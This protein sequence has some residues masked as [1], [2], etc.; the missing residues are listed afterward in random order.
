[1][2]KPSHYV[3]KNKFKFHHSHIIAV[4]VLAGYFLISKAHTIQAMRSGNVLT[5]F[6]QLYL[7]GIFFACLFL[8][9]FSHD[10]FF[11]FA[12]DIEKTESKKEKKYLNKYLHHGKILGT[13]I[14]GSIGGPVFS[15]LT[16]RILLNDYWYK[17][18]IVILANIPSTIITVGLGT[19]IINAF[20]IL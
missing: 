4:A 9:V 19:G 14:I 18:L 12:K 3:V 13:L 1:M 7:F 5:S 15:S 2:R 10:K 6:I 8:Y 16:A 20:N 11:G 17:Y